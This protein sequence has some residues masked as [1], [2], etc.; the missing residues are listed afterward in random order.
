VQQHSR[1]HH[2]HPSTPTV[3][4]ILKQQ[5]QVAVRNPTGLQDLTVGVGAELPT[6]PLLLLVDG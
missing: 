1:G 2:Q 6:G 5:A 3:L 4:G